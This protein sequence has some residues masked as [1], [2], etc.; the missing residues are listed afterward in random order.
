VGLG[1]HRPRRA[2]DEKCEPQ[3]VVG[4]GSHRPRRAKD[5]KCEPQDVAGPQCEPQPKGEVSL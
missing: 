2:K 1:S 3:D 4:L 5:E